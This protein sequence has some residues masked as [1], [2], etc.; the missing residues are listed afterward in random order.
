MSEKAKDF[1][2]IRAPSSIETYFHSLLPIEPGVVICHTGSAQSSAT[3][4]D[5]TS[6][7]HQ[8]G[9]SEQ[10][11]N[12]WRKLKDEDHERKENR[13][14]HISHADATKI[15]GHGEDGPNSNVGVNEGK[16]DKRYLGAL[17]FG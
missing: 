1:K 16:G 7:E 15:T 14:Q 2:G 5:H 4:L 6:S 8:Q 3:P 17:L 11:K 12:L 9:L 10:A 13:I